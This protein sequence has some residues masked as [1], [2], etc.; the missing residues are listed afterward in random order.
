MINILDILLIS[1]FSASFIQ[2]SRAIWPIKNLI[3]KKI[4]P[5]A[6]DLC[7]SF[8]IVLI[9]S[10]VCYQDGFYV[11]IEKTLLTAGCSFILCLWLVKQTSNIEIPLLEE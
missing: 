4:K 6:C 8:W 9:T 1:L 2:I 10:S 7:M 5:F 11:P 3:K